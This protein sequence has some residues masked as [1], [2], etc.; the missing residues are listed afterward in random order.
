MRVLL[1]RSSSLD[2][3]PCGKCTVVTCTI[4]CKSMSK[5]RA[6]LYT[7]WKCQARTVLWVGGGDIL[8]SVL[9]F[10][11][12]SVTQRLSLFLG[13]WNE[14]KKKNSARTSVAVKA[15]DQLFPIQTRSN[16]LCAVLHLMC[17]CICVL[18]AGSHPLWFRSLL[19]C[20]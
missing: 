12:S 11:D 10:L 17:F 2:K 5:R 4:R 16:G 20:R 14:K 7:Q 15:F 6:E 3:I 18:L 1:I 8:S 13:K 9:C 19:R